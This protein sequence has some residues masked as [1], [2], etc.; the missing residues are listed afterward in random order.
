MKNF[1]IGFVCS[2]NICRSPMA[3]YMFKSIIPPGWKNMT[4]IESAGT[5][6]ITGAPAAQEAIQVLREI[7]IDLTPHS[8]RGIDLEWLKRMDL[9]FVMSQEHID[10]IENEYPQEKSK[11]FRLRE[12]A[13][14]AADQDADYDIADPVGL[15][16]D[17]FRATR[18]QINDELLRILPVL[19]ARIE[20][21][22]S[23]APKKNGWFKW[24]KK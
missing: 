9:V 15:S 4:R 20:G 14:N 22:E 3:E 24:I 16:L 18:E 12:Y 13:R 5:L 8:S 19:S 21:N 23:R 6:G 7:E 17:V 11:V 1:Q 10:F 2:G